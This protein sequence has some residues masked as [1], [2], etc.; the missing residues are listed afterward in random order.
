[1]KEL[2]LYRRS[3]NIV[4]QVRVSGEKVRV[5]RRKG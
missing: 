4:E 5:I 1:M 3:K 2:A